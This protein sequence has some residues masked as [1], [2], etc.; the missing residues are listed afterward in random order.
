MYNTGN[1]VPSA[2]LEDMADNAQTFDALVTKTEGTTTDRKGVNRRVFQQIIMDMGFQ[3]LSGS[4]Q[5]GATITARNQTLYDEVSHV[6]YA[7][8]GALPKVV[9]SGSTPATAGGIGISA[10]S[11]KTDLML[12]ESVYVQTHSSFKTINHL[13][14]GDSKSGDVD[15]SRLVGMLV[16]TDQHN[17]YADN[18]SP[19][20]GAKYKI[21][22]SSDYGGTPDGYLYGGSYYIGGDFYVGGSTDYVA[23]LIGNS[24]GELDICMFGAYQGQNTIISTLAIQLALE[25]A[26]GKTVYIPEG[27]FN[28]SD[29]V[30]IN[31]TSISLCGRKKPDVY[32][33]YSRLING[34]ILVGS[35]FFRPVYGCFLNFG[36]DHG[37]NEF[38]TAGDALKISATSPTAGKW[39]VVSGC[40]GLGRAASDATHSMLVE[41]YSHAE[42]LNVTGVRNYFG[43]AAKI[44]GGVINGVTAIDNGTYNVIVKADSAYGQL[45]DINISNINV[46][47][48]SVLTSV[49]L[50]VE[51]VDSQQI[52]RININ[53]VNGK[54]IGTIL[55]FNAASGVINDINASNIIGQNISADAIYTVGTIYSLSLNNCDVSACAAR[56]LNIPGIRFIRISNFLGHCSSAAT[57]L[58]FNT[59]FVNIGSSAAR[60]KISN[61]DL[62]ENYNT[63]GFGKINYANAADQ[64]R[65]VNYS[66]VLSGVGVPV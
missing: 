2:A 66:A 59:D 37:S 32:S 6:F 9:P 31:I 23:K 62:V 43:L 60:T 21:M 41:G 13:V 10:W 11:D 36:V 58:N 47:G 54:N 3:P 49:A 17:T 61:I 14:N 39:V 35:A 29:T 16:C 56:A 55:R 22:T 33:D 18:T 4:F 28:Y 64:N 25:Y 12:R 5:T 44:T 46:L 20:G 34:S 52:Q 26:N 65:I 30:G 15:F 40:I 48:V 8:G 27:R 63:S 38:L 53:N 1:P 7:W 57:N 50:E 51:C 24:S 42:I 45:R 19:E